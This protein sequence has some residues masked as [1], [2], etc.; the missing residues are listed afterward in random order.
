MVRDLYLSE[1]IMTRILVVEDSPTQAQQLA[2]LLADAGFEVEIAATAAQG[3]AHATTGEFDLI[4]VDVYLPDESGFEL[5]RRVKAHARLKRIPILINTADSDPKNV[6]RGLAAG[7]DGFMTK[8]HSSDEILGR[9]QRTL[10]GGARLLRT[11]D[12][13][14][15]KVTFQDTDFLLNPTIEQLLNILL[16]AFEDVINLNLRL[17]ASEAALLELN[18][19]IRTANR[20]LEEANKVKDRFLSMAAHDL[21]NPIGNISVM[22]S[23][24]RDDECDSAER[25]NF[26]DSMIRQSEQMLQL[27]EDLLCASATR[28]GKL[29]LKPVLQDPAKVLRQAFDRFLLPARKKGVQ[30]LWEVPPGLPPTE[31]DSERLAEVLSNLISN[32]LKFCSPGQSVTLGARVVDSKLEIWVRDNGP[33]IQKAELPHLFD[34]FTKLSNRPTGGEP[35]TGLGLSIV[36]QIVELHGGHV[37]VQSVVGQGT[38]FT[39]QLPL[40]YVETVTN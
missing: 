14:C 15:I 7:A 11:G 4:M 35:S 34:P 22:A 39:L 21:R 24:M 28:T 37:S 20:A 12:F 1:K 23:M 9:V 33:G 25:N 10:N 17:K 2:I 8:D 40:Y 18:T 3:Y 5:C 13:D 6:L 32:G 31:L 29:E 16:S 27:I 36:K 19:E 26:L 38:M 30:L